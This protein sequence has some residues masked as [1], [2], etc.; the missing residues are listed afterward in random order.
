MN[1]QTAELPP[2]V[3]LPACLPYVSDYCCHRCCCRAQAYVG[4]FMRK[5]ADARAAAAAGDM[6]VSLQ[7]DLLGGLPADDW[8]AACVSGLLCVL[9]SM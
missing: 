7:D 1:M 8:A 6:N 3:P 4:A 2:W 5:G 9:E